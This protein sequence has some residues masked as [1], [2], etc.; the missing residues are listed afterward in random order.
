M[1]EDNGTNGAA[2]EATPVATAPAPEP[3]SAHEAVENVFSNLNRSPR[4]ESFQRTATSEPEN[5]PSVE[6]AP[7]TGQ[8]AP[9]SVEP[10][11]PAINWEKRYN[12]LQSDY[13]RRAKNEASKVEEKLR[14]EFQG[15]MQQF[16]QAV[17]QRNQQQSSTQPA[18]DGYDRPMTRAE[19][20]QYAAQA[21]EQIVQQRLAS[22]PRLQVAGH[23]GDWARYREERQD[24][25]KYDPFV[26]KLLSKF[27]VPQ[28][29]NLHQ[30][31]N[32][33]YEFFAELEA[34]AQ[35]LQ[36]NRQGEAAKGNNT[37]PPQQVHP[38]GQNQQAAALMERA[39]RY[40]MEQGVAPSAATRPAIDAFG[41]EEEAIDAMVSAWM[42]GRR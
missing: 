6:N 8:S 9:P 36:A 35:A 3:F 41:N 11:A 17:L 37:P 23:I 40:R 15:Q 33:A 20:M 34:E 14:G 4:P 2:A 19:A 16:A 21:A 10:S 12:D 7:H 5:T 1:P 38:N 28:G 29:G 42:R 27:P 32:S 26:T 18:D 22:D 39:A 25:T 31:L 30:H 13:D 24:S